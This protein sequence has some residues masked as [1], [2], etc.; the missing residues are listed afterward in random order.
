MPAIT[1]AQ[2]QRNDAVDT[3]TENEAARGRA[4][5]GATSANE[6]S[7]K[8]IGKCRAGDYVIHVGIFPIKGWLLWWYCLLLM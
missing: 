4:A 6:W 3:A 1:R 2:R 7:Y 8:I 5:R